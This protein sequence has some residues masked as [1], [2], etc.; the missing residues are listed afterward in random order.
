MGKN[1][2]NWEEYSK[3]HL[4]S[5]CFPMMLELLVLDSLKFLRSSIVNESTMVKLR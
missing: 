3:A 1:E 2:P 5:K 4:S